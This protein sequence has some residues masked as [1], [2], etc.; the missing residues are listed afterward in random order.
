MSHPL[1][2]PV[3][4][5]PTFE[6][7]STSLA[8]NELGVPLEPICEFGAGYKDPGLLFDFR[9]PRQ[10]VVEFSYNSSK[11]LQ[12]PLIVVVVE[13]QRPVA[14]IGIQ[15]SIKGLRRRLKR[16]PVSGNVRRLC[17]VLKVP[18]RRLDPLGIQPFPVEVGAGGLATLGKAPNRFVDLKRLQIHELKY[19]SF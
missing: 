1:I 9:R 19:K 7:Q 6:R 5:P 14:E 15:G 12:V 17:G 18:P 11:A 3:G 10:H 16:P 2:N 4:A 13:D 8:K